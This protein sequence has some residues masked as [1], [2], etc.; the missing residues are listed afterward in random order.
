MKRKSNWIPY[1]L[2][3]GK[4]AY[5]AYKRFKANNGGRGRDYRR[6]RMAFRGGSAPVT[7]QFDVRTQYV[8][9]R[10]SRQR[11]RRQKKFKK[12]AERVKQSD[13][14]LRVQT[15]IYNYWA[16]A[17]ADA[18]AYHGFLLGGP[19]GTAGLNDDLRILFNLDAN[20]S[21][22]S[23]T[24]L[25]FKS[26]VMDI[27]VVNTSE[28]TV[29][30]DAYYVLCRK[31]V[32]N[33]GYGNL[34]QAFTEATS[35]MSTFTGGTNISAA[36]PGISPFDIPNFCEKFIIT[37]KQRLILSPGQVSSFVVKDTKR[38]KIESTDSNEYTLLKGQK[39]VLFVFSAAVTNTLD[40]PS[41]ELSF[42]VN[43]SYHYYHFTANTEVGGEHP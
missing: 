30:V 19:N 15:F 31:M 37:K 21:N 7:N 4:L 24:Q 33:S 9:K 18:Q 17:A 42:S 22:P 25:N 14:A 38:R 27:E 10:Q 12:F 16:S 34:Q 11:R 5:N 39:G 2:A 23:N 41:S 26:M 32:S 6:T 1:A 13:A 8:G 3:G 20:T 36:T 35:E 40:I 29:I 28:V 43:R